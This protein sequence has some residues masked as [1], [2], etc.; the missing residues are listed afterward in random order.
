MILKILSWFTRIFAILSILFLMMFSLD[1]FGGNEPLIRQLLGFLKHNI[2]A[3]A[4]IIALII[5]WKYE[6]AG[7]VI[8]ILLFIALGIFWR[9][10]SGNSGSL[11]LIAPYFIVGILFILHRI[12]SAKSKG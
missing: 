6:F 1:V 11:I 2:P 12:L 10:F 3:F 7:G 9:S 8:F 5:A 4:L